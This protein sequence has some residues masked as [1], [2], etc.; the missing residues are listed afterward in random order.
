MA[1]CREVRAEP[2]TSSAVS[3]VQY[4]I[5]RRQADDEDGEVAE[6]QLPSAA[7]KDA[8]RAADTSKAAVVAH[9]P[10]AAGNDPGATTAAAT[11]TGNA[12]AQ[13]AM[14]NAATGGPRDAA[15]GSKPWTDP[16]PA[17]MKA[18]S[19]SG[20]H[21]LDPLGLEGA[22]GSGYNMDSTT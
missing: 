10:S 21:H 1:F 17:Q 3:G 5:T 22:G 16:V 7:D 18:H 15:T 6:S 9:A 19:S 8:A 12:A 2:P 11:A 4:R 13:T 14:G 20:Q